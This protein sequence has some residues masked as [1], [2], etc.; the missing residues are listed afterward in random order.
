MLLFEGVDR[1]TIDFMPVFKLAA[2][3]M[4]CLGV[5]CGYLSLIHAKN[6]TMDTT[7]VANPGGRKLGTGTPFS[8]SELVGAE[9]DR[10]IQMAKDEKGYGVRKQVILKE[11]VRSEVV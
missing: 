5:A 4:T 11:L 3:L 10:L 7:I 2:E 6:L 1:E 8:V 9:T